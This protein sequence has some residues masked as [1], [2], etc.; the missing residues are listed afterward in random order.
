MDTPIAHDQELKNIADMWVKFPI[1]VRQ[2][3]IDRFNQGDSKYVTGGIG[4]EAKFDRDISFKV[5]NGV[6]IFAEVVKAGSD[7][8]CC[9]L[10]YALLLCRI[11]QKMDTEHHFYP[12]RA[13]RRVYGEDEIASVPS[14]SV[15]EKCMAN[16]VL[17]PRIRIA[18]EYDR[19]TR[20]GIGDFINVHSAMLG[21]DGTMHLERFIPV[22]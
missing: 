9:P 12:L 5:N 8:T 16:L 6:S 3:T 19:P 4:V 14:T 7:I 10:G 13:S 18:D 11:D 21:D 15:L 17:I 1:E 20:V 2:Q 22:E